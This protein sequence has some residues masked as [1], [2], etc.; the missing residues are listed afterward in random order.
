MKMTMM[1]TALWMAMGFASF[2]ALAQSDIAP[3]APQTQMRPQTESAPASGMQGNPPPSM[4]S[5][6]P[7][8]AQGAGTSGTESH[9]RSGASDQM[10]SE[11]GPQFNTAPEVAMGPQEKT[12]G[13]VTYMCG[14]VGQDEVKY[15]KQ[16]A[17][18]YDLMLTFAA[19]SGA[20][21]ADVNVDVRDRKGNPVLQANCDA[22]IMLINLPQSGTYH[23]RAET[24]NGY[25]LNQVATVSAG[26][27]RPVER[28]AMVWPQKAAETGGTAEISSGGGGENSHVRGGDNTQRRMEERGG[29]S[30]S[31]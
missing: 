12:Q 26:H 17:K 27:Q 14:G 5:G 13:D 10:Q 22:P 3:A 1:T 18:N 28:L 2:P 9:S 11:A 4:Q 21:L 6:M 16:Q 31:Q 24:N 25:S 8:P 7:P 20:Y 15:M 29:D 23:V 19:R 30:S